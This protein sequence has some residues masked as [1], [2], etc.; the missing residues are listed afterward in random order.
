MS[1]PIITLIKKDILLEFRQKHTLFSILLY[2]VST[3]FSLYMMNGQPEVTVWNALFWIAQ[4]FITV[5]TVAKS[6]LQEKPESL[7]Y[8]F[9]IVSPLQFVIS[10]LLYSFILTLFMTLLS[11]IL[12]VT[13]LGNPL[14]NFFTFFGV[15]IVGALNLGLLFTFLS[16]VAAQARQ[17]AAMMAV[18]GFPIAIPMLIILSKMTQACLTNVVQEGMLNMFFIMGFMSMMIFVLASILFPFLW[19]E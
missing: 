3:V 11:F 6:F 14:L 8:Y 18:L 17:N 1:H 9:T 12:F 13:L 16:A 5:N 2:M 4:L 10:K 19:Q 7:R 15:A